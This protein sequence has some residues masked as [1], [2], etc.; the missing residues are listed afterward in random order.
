[1]GQVYRA[2]DTTLGR[3]VAIKIL[4]DAFASDPERL[5]RFE[6][7]AKTLA[8]LNHPHIAAIY[9]VEKSGGT[10]ALVMELVEG[11]DLSQWIERGAIPLDEALPI[12]KQIAEALEA[13][14]D[15]GIIHR[16]LKPANIKV[17]TDGTVK[18]LDFGLAKAVEPVGS[19]AN[20]SQ[21][22]TLT[23][24]AMTQA[25]MI[26]G[27]AAYMSPEQAKGRVVDKRADIWAFGVI[28]S[29]MLSGRRLF[30]AEDVPETLA[31]VLTRD[32][33]MPTL[34]VATPLRLQRLL[35][36]CLERDPKT[37][38]RD[39]GEARVEIDRTIAGTG[40][41]AVAS[42]TSSAASSGSGRRLAWM[43]F[44]VAT[45]GVLAAAALSIPAVR[46]LRETLP[47]EMRV[48]LSTP[49]TLQPLQFALSPDGRQIVFVASGTGQQRLWLRALDTIEAQPLA[50]TEGAEYP[51]WSAD[52][53]SLGFFANGKL[54]RLDI[55]GGSPQPLVTTGSSARG[56]AWSAIR[57]RGCATSARRASRSTGPSRGRAMSRSR[58]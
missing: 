41:V 54:Y 28:V 49:S 15:Q 23:T 39:I 3:E 18:V 1:M 35:A 19:A 40:D 5:A 12:A 25:G 57:K 53:R 30:G 10:H 45:V 36:R 14:H 52:G 43:S 8:L 24:P 32:I 46:H 11:D 29:E 17:K 6:R 38:L 50:G 34:P 31:A 7:E 4:P 37:R 13:A 48:E 55:A 42:V 26:L 20:V 56:G 16:D 44:A 2:T 21:S 9:S 51:F 58:R 33:S 47:P 22:P 27:T